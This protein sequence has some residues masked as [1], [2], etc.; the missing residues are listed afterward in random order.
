MKP[1]GAE[2]ERGDEKPA[3]VVLS[4]PTAAGKTAAAIALASRVGGEIVSADSIQIYRFMDI[5]SAKPTPQER[6]LVPHHLIDI[7]NPDEDFTAG[8]YMRESRRAVAEILSRGR[9]PLIVGGT[10]L[11]IRSLMW[12][13][14]P[15][16]QPD[17]ELRARLAREAETDKGLYERLLEIDPGHAAA[18]GPRNVPRLLRALEVFELTGRTLSSLQRSHRFSDRP[19]RG[20]HVCLSP[21]R[22]ILYDRIDKR[23]DDMLQSG[24]IDEVSGLLARGWSA[25]LKPMKSLGYRHACMVLSGRATIEHAARLMKR[26]TRRY[27]KRQLT[28]FRSEPEALWWDPADQ[29]GL[30]LVVDDFL[31]R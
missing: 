29:C 22:L 13:V 15:L 21:P 25:D 7:R 16:P 2:M 8:D 3:V 20:L 18:I 12:G 31:G 19:Y 11:Y 6:A 14:I 17:P 1:L 9:V 4:G 28:W 23:V 26:D 10:G 30:Q 27:A 24:L 5:G